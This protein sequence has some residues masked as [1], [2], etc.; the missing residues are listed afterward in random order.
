MI[1]LAENRQKQYLVIKTKDMWE[2]FAKPK[3]SEMDLKHDDFCK[4]PLIKSCRFAT[5][6]ISLLI[7][8]LPSLKLSSFVLNMFGTLYI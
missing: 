2:K 7:P 5:H 6:Y 1:T 3:G 8:Q 4:V